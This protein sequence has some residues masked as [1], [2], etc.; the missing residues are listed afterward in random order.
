M[1]ELRCEGCGGP[2]VLRRG[3]QVILG[4]VT[5]MTDGLTGAEVWESG[6]SWCADC[7]RSWNERMGVDG[8]SVQ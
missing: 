5:V 4:S 8:G 2:I 6:P 3:D 1:N 7:I